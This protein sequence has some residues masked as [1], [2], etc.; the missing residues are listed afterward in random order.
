MKVQLIPMFAENDAAITVIGNRF[1]IGRAEDC[2]LRIA[3]RRV[4]RHHC[5][6]ILDGDDLFVRDLKSSN[7]TF[8]NDERI[9]DEH[10]LSDNDFLA[11]AHS[12]YLVE[13]S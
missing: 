3:D 13:R 11:L 2:D 12:I 1:S 4:S 10:P 5:E 6:L 9:H 7:G 8:V